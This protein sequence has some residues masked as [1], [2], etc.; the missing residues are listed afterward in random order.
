MFLYNAGS[1]P[2]S[3][4]SSNSLGGGTKMKSCHLLLHL[5]V[6]GFK[7]FAACDRY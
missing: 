6:F 1:R 3:Y 2:E 5:V 7:H 4:V